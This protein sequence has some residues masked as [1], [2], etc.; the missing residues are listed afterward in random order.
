MIT[1]F[2]MLVQTLLH[3]IIKYEISNKKCSNK[4]DKSNTK[5]TTIKFNSF[6][7]EFYDSTPF[8][9]IK[10]SLLSVV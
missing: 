5:N 10:I 6:C 4:T 3:E 2:C 9:K 7:P 8:F 1:K